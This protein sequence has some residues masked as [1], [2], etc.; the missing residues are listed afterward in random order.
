MS[1]EK[2]IKVYLAGDST[3]QS[4]PEERAPQAGW[5]QYIAEHFTTKVLFV[6]RAIGGR[7]SKTFVEEGRLAEILAEIG[8]GDYL[9]VQMGHNDATP[10]R[11]ERYTE[12]FGSY[13]DYLRQYITGAREHGARP[14]LITPMGRLHYE[15]GVF[16]NDF[17]DYCT[18]MKELAEEQGVP[19]VD[20]M[21]RSLADYA[22]M[23]YD[24]AQRLFMISVNGTDLTHFTEAGAQRIAALL[25]EGVRELGIP[26]SEQVPVLQEK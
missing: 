4:Y 10:S 3:V 9:F 17:A 26:L 1:A 22:A 2:K 11:P 13:K 12:P 14:V 8:E 19:L 21:T 15:D 16:L 20:L 24:E 6:N 25:A 18:A 5:G 7:S 23:G